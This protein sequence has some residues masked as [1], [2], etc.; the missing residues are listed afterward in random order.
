[1]KAAGGIAIGHK[2]LAIGFDFTPRPEYVVFFDVKMVH[3]DFVERA[4]PGFPPNTAFYPVDVPP[5]KTLEDAI[6]IFH[7]Q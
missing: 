7:L 2:S 6:R 5:G 1:M 3:A 4:K